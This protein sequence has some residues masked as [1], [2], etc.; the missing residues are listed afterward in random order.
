MG[1]DGHAIVLLGGAGAGKTALMLAALQA[2]WTVLSDDHLLIDASGIV[3]GMPRRMRIHDSTLDVVPGARNALFPAERIRQVALSLLRHVTLG[4]IR[5]P[6]LVAAERFGSFQPIAPVPGARIVAIR[7]EA[8]AE[9]GTSEAAV[10]QMLELAVS[11]VARER[12]AVL[13]ALGPAWRDHLSDVV[14][15][16]RAILREAITPLRLETI[17]VPMTW[18]PSRTLDHLVEGRPSGIRT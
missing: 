16:E 12:A 5:L 9:P 17:V 6:N 7:R 18:S 15:E 14:L 11:A 2:G 1:P 13:L 10:D 3:R 8:G 4:Q